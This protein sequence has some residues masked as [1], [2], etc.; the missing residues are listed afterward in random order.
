MSHRHGPLLA[1]A[2]AAVIAL[3]A[4]PAAHAAERAVLEGRAIQP[5]GPAPA[6]TTTACP[7]TAPDAVGAIPEPQ[8]AGGYSELLKGRAGTYWA[9][10]DNGYGA[11]SNSCD[12]ILRVDRVR[13]DYALDG[14]GER[15]GSVRVLSSIRLRDP[16]QRIPFPIYRGSTS[17]RLLTGWD[18]DPESM[19]IDRSGLVVRR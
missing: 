5:Y 6:Q 9:M 16:D 4:T 7:A 10:P 13:V 15:P 11:K 17:E 14:S 1:A 12:F 2:A 18:F 3:A 8:P 19:R